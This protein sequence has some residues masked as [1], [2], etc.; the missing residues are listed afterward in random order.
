[1]VK[2]G[3]KWRLCIDFRAVN[4][5]TMADGSPVPNMMDTLYKLVGGKIF[6]QMDIAKCYHQLMM[7]EDARPK[8]AFS[9]GLQHYEYFVVPFGLKN[10]PG[11][12]VRFL[13]GHVFADLDEEPLGVF[14][15]DMNAATK[16]HVPLRTLLAK[17]FDRLRKHGLVLRSE[18]CLFGSKSIKTL[19]F[20]IDQ[21]GI[22]PDEAKL[23]AIKHY[24][25]P[26][27]PKELRSFLGLVNFNGFFVAKLQDTLSPLNAAVSQ[28]PQTFKLGP[29]ELQAFYKAKELFMNELRLRLPD[30]SQPFR[31]TTDAS[32]TGIAGILSQLDEAG[33]NWPIAFFSRSLLEHRD[34]TSRHLEHYAFLQTCRH[35]RQFLL[36]QQFVWVTDHKPLQHEQ[37]IENSRIRR[38]DMELKEYDYVTDWVR[39]SENALADALKA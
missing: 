36:G 18:K 14:I 10:V 37:L 33:Q 12:V 4:K 30:F 28:C 16:D 31:I 8:T 25:V 38:W 23:E 26:T 15:D 24:P 9:V 6:S 7:A 22:R 1:M 19:G 34:L 35:W 2:Q 3:E 20:I 13:C 29:R 17:I 11:A 5:I 39:G 27:T 32:Q 21:Q